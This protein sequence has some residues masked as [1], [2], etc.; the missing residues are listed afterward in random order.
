MWIGWKQG[1]IE[2]SLVFLSS[3]IQ[4]LHITFMPEHV[5]RNNSQLLLF[6][7]RNWLRFCATSR[8]VAGSDPN[9]V[10]GIFH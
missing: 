4:L 1:L 9:S 5:A 7:W 3:R 10:T 6:W 2:M 8:R